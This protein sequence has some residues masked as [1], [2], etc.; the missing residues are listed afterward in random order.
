MR[1]CLVFRTRVNALIARGLVVVKLAVIFFI[2]ALGFFHIRPAN[3][4]PLVPYGGGSIIQA[5]SLVFFAFLG[6]D[7]VAI[8]AEESRHPERD[9]PFGI[10]GSLTS[11]VIT[12]E[13]S[14]P[15]LRLAAQLV[16]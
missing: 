11:A 9:V 14:Y 7:V 2:L 13:R 1:H 10:I 16:H 15:A 3:W 12:S 4:T 5:A 8:T 6:F